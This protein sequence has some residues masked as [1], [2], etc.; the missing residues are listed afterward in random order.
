MGR[1][2]SRLG[3]HRRFFGGVVLLACTSLCAVP[4]VVFAADLGPVDSGTLSTSTVAI[5]P[6]AS[7]RDLFP[8]AAGTAVNG[9]VADFNNGSGWSVNAGPTW[10]ADAGFLINPA[11]G[12]VRH[13]TGAVRS[14]ALVPYLTHDVRAELRLSATTNATD[15]GPMI[16]SSNVPAA[17]N[18]VFMDIWTIGAT[19]ATIALWDMQTGAACGTS[20]TSITFASGTTTFDLTISYDAP[21]STLTGTVTPLGGSTTTRTCTY[22]P[23][24][25]RSYAGMM[26]YA[27]SPAR[28]SNLL[29]TYL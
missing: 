16:Y 5:T 10:S 9:L 22:T 14:A 7:V 1:D 3:G 28:F 23:G 12:S 21:T 20:Q 13:Q 29:L 25:G 15:A 6:V 19:T 17:P 8:E 4:G 27:N 2:R 24:A 26:S 11:S 18:G